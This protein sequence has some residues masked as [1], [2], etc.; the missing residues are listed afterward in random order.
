MGKSDRVKKKQLDSF[1][2]NVQSKE[3]KLLSWIDRISFFHVFLIWIGSITLFGFIYYFGTTN[4]SYLIQTQLQIPVTSIYEHIYF[5][6]ITATSTGFGDV[7][8]KGIFQAL[9]IT[10]VV[11]GLVMLAIV[12]SK[13]VSVKQNVILTEVYEIS[14]NEKLN[15]LRSSFALFRLN[16][17]KVIS[18]IEERKI[19]ARE[20]RGSLIHFATLQETL[21]EISQ[22]FIQSRKSTYIKIIDTVSAENLLISILRS[23]SRVNDFLSA[24]TEYKIEIHP[25]VT[26][27]SLHQIIK[28]TERIFR[29]G[30]KVGNFSEQTW[31]E[32][33]NSKE[34]ELSG[35]KTFLNSH[36]KLSK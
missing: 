13:L 19:K 8:P 1:L 15:R 26:D 23:L 31:A 35:L 17:N 30:K 33:E 2:T 4:N 5:S 29:N 22:L 28:L 6:F 32:L 21:K 34:K 16:I 10:E 7:T 18:D 11:L 36:K 3:S 27:K 25:E 9:A 24:I 20:A 14:F 12:T